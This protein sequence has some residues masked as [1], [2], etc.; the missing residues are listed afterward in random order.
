MDIKC[1]IV[2]DEPPAQRVL[3]KYIEDIPMLKL[4]GKCRDALEAMDV[5]RQKPVDLM[6]LDIN[7]PRITGLD[8]LQTLSNPPLVIITTAY[9]DYALESFELNVV[10][11]LR[12]PIPFDRFLKATNKATE[13]LS[14]KQRPATSIA[15]PSRP[16]SEETFIFVKDDKVTYRVDLVDLLYVESVGDYVKLVTTQKVFVTNQTMKTMEQ[17]LPSSRFIRVHKSFIVS[18]SKIHNV[19][20]NVIKLNNTLIPIG[21]TYRKDFFDLIDIS[22]DL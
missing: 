8:F 14:L 3:E 1:I 4:Q 18:L 2:D 16:K 9:R 5:L 22:K 7:M 6:F 15:D 21:Q 17:I 10:D 12:K 11:Y 13:L 20:G 19:D